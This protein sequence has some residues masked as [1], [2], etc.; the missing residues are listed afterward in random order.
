MKNVYWDAAAGEYRS[1]TASGA[2]ADAVF[3]GAMA[4]LYGLIA[5]GVVTTAA[6]AVVS[7]RLELLPGIAGGFGL[8]GYLA[9][10]GVWMAAIF[11][12]NFAVRRVSPGIGALLYLGFTALTGLMIS[13]ILWQYAGSSIVLALVLTTCVFSVMSVI[14]FT[15]KRDLSGLGTLC[16]IGLVGVIIAGIAN[17][18]IGSGLISWLVTLVALPVFLG[19]TVYETKQIKEMAQEAASRGDERAAGQIAVYGAM[20]LYVSFLNLFLILLRIL[21]L[22]N[23]GG[24]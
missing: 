22:F 19:L 14:G 18:F 20:G 6:S 4:R 21:D 8:Y 1:L 23:G 7:Y 15:T 2:A 12:V 13:S 16:F 11:G 3:S 17:I 9:M 24:D 5:L 10:L